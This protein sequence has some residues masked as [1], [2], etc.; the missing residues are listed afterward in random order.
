MTTTAACPPRIDPGDAHLLDRLLNALCGAPERP[1]P[2]RG[3]AFVRPGQPLPAV[4]TAGGVRFAPEGTAPG[5]EAVVTY[6]GT[7]DLDGDAEI[8]L[9]GSAVVTFHPYAGAEFSPGSGL[10]ML[11]V[12]D[13]VDRAEFL[14]HA[15]AARD[16]GLWASHLLEPATFLADQDTLA[17]TLSGHHPW[18]PRYLDAV[19]LLRRLRLAG[20]PTGEVRVSG[21]GGA[22]THDGQ[23]DV[24]PRWEA[25]PTLYAVGADLRLASRDGATVLRLSR[26]AARLYELRLAGAPRPNL[27]RALGVG[28]DAVAA[29]LTALMARLPAAGLG[30]FDDDP[31]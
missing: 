4:R 18:L 8:V 11:V 1:G 25:A 10:R 19:R 14:R 13:A 29:A 31:E 9:F 3:D 5:A 21:F 23:A 6:E 30:G 28:E 16:E 20:H 26:D 15:A 17:G 22:L 2:A 27:A 24:R 7:P 12:D